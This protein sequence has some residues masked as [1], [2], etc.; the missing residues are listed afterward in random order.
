[1]TIST[2]YIGMGCF[3]GV[4]KF[5]SQLDF[6]THTK[7]GYMGGNAQN[8][9][10]TLVCTGSTGHA[11]VVKVD[12]QPGHDRELLQ[13]FFE[14][15]DPTQENGQGADIGTQYRSLIFTTTDQQY[16]LATEMRNI[17]QNKLSDRGFGLIRTEIHPPLELTDFWPAEEY[18]QNY[19]AKNPGGYC[20]VHAT[21]IQC[22]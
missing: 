11:E 14:N 8:P 2:M 9:T 16:Q 20:P 15:H 17:A 22:G 4:Q 6:V 18:H 3:W 19:L 21:G 7:V 5:V 13:F 12:Y 1:M 10:Y